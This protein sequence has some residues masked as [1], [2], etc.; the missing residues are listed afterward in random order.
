[1]QP[2]ISRETINRL[3]RDVR[4]I[5]KF[6]LTD[7][8]IYYSH[9][10]TDMFKGYALIIG[11][12][13]TPYFGGYYFFKFMFPYDYPFSPPRVTFMTNDGHIR[14]N[15]NLYTNGKVCVSILNT[16]EGEQWSSCQTISSVLLALCT[17]LNESPLENE[18]GYS[19]TDPEYKPYQK[20]IEYSNINFAI[21][22]MINLSNNLIPVPFNLFYPIMREKFLKNYD[23][24]M[25][26][27]Q[28]QNNYE[29]GCCVRIY[30]MGL[31]VNYNKL[32]LKLIN[33]KKIVE[34]QIQI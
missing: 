17:L 4:Q 3:L 23:K 19:K 33:T 2:I 12:E 15:P 34:T 31:Y 32:N 18:P 20:I 16:W 29:G 5:I 14:Y 26:F 27:I 8:G 10:D 22:D 28:L 30:N 21:C 1:M 7:S 24:L 11:P 25:E 9:D 13:N 6:P